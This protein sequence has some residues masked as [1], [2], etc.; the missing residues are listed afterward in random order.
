VVHKFILP[1]LGN[2]ALNQAIVIEIVNNF[3]LINELP[4]AVPTQSPVGAEFSSDVI[5]QITSP[6]S[7]CGGRP[8]AAE[9]GVDKEELRRST[10]KVAG[11]VPPFG[12]RR[13]AQWHS[14]NHE[15]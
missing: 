6:Q 14:V 7:G 10:D 12:K 9:R 8:T 13:L 11:E 5:E 2:V 1:Q 15:P 3:R 4:P